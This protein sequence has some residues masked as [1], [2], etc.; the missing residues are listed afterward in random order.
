M[1]IPLDD[2]VKVKAWVSQGQAVVLVRVA[3][4]LGST[5]RESGAEMAVTAEALAGTIGGGRLEW[6][7]L[8]EARR[9]LAAGETASTL[10]VPLGPEIGQCCGGRV[11][12]SFAL[13]DGALLAELEGRALAQMQ[14]RPQ[15]LVFG[16]GHTGTALA[17]AL[18]PL[19]LAVTLVDSRPET[20]AAAIPGVRMLPLAM[21]EVSVRDAAPGAA[22]VA[23]THSHD[24]DFL[25]TAEALARGDAAYAG[26]IGSATKRAVFVNWLEA[27]GYGR[28]LAEKLVCPI[29]GDKVRDKRPEVIAALTAAE[30]ATALL[31]QP[32][33]TTR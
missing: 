6:I 25:V 31:A 14:A 23:M 21:P 9:L 32:S 27:N 29:G 13:V 18:A 2:Y 22:F 19:P 1:A 24:L 11:R 16:A 15:A 20:L 30:I 8:D 3:Q 26:M 4:A 17:R 7:A 33:P 12:L 10:D 5:P 28:E